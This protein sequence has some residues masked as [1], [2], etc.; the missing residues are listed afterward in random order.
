MSEIT[1]ELTERF[2]PPNGELKPEILT[3]LQSILRLHNISPEELSYKWESYCM[4]MGA[5]ET[6]M[7]L[8]TTRD[9]KKDLLETVERESRAKAAKINDKRNVNATPRATMGSDVFG[10][11]DGLVPNTPRT[12][13]SR[14]TGSTIKRKSNFET[15]A[16]KASKNHPASSPNTG[17]TPSG[18]FLERTNAGEVVESFGEHIPL[19]KT[20]E[21]PL[22]Q[23]RIKLAARIDMPK[24]GYKTMAMKL[25]EASE[26]LD[27]R[28]EDFQQ[29]IQEHYNLEDNAFGNPARESQSEVIAVGRIA[30]D[31][32]EGKLN[33]PSLVLEGSRKSGSGHR[34]PLRVDKL[35]SYSFFPGKIVA[36]KGTNASGQFF[37]ATEVLEIPSMNRAATMPDE[38]DAVNNR[39][40]AGDDE[41]ETRP[42]TT[43]IASG[44]Y[45]TEEDLDYSPFNALLDAAKEAQADTLILCGPFVDVEHP[46]IRDGDIEFPPDFKV[47]PDQ[48]T[49]T[50]V[51]RCF[52]SRP[53]QALAK[54]LPSISIILCPSLRDVFDKHAAWPQDRVAKQ[55]LGLSGKQ[56]LIVTNPMTIAMNENVFGMSSLDVLDQLRFS[57]VTF[58]KAS[59]ENFLARTCKQLIEQRHYFP[60]MPAAER[61]PSANAVAGDAMQFNAIGASLD[62]SFM[63]LGEFH[64]IVPD[65]LIL[66]SVLNSFTK[67]VDGVVCINPGTLSKKRGPGTYARM[68]ITPRQLT[69]EEREAGE[70]V[71]HNV[72]ERSRVDIVRI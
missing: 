68:T 33:T 20:R 3:E 46:K 38:I 24:Y 1:A 52:I 58:G 36:L 26:Y 66:P 8:K 69:T 2:A 49:L 71:T 28:I 65:V 31:S 39:L 56:I 62:I 57:S 9:F 21:E 40:Q 25:T 17:A 19:A 37:S 43:F 18:A 5:E 4:K 22:P 15:P 60:L 59:Q 32:M 13:G 29:L 61:Q 7:D 51:F 67:I 34:V 30:S 23:S 41:S 53:L 45:T 63:K 47:Q 27:D 10:M 16:S 72:Y 70:V 64:Q 54:A 48:A 35:S 42:F 12:G 11:L 6:K 50:D 55:G 44:P 14:A